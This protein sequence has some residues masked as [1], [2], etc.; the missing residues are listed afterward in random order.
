MVGNVILWKSL[1]TASFDS[2]Y[3]T[4][5]IKVADE[6]VQCIANKSLA[7]EKH[8][9]CSSIVSRKRQFFRHL[10]LYLIG[11]WQTEVKNLL[12]FRTS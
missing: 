10:S 11:P 7:S 1:V 8:A 4:C 3:N 2:I 12:D 9:V 5:Y 6:N